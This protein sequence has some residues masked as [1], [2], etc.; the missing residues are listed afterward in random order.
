[1]HDAL[2][3]AAVSA[4]PMAAAASGALDDGFVGRAVE[5]R[6]IAELLAQDDCRLV[7]VVGPGGIGKTRFAQRAS[8]ELAARF[9]DGT[10]F[11]PLEDV[12]TAGE[13]GSRLAREMGIVISGGADPLKKV[14]AFLR[15]RRMLVVLDNFEHLAADAAL[16]DDVVRAC[17]Q[18]KFI[19]TSRVRLAIPGEW[20]L[21]LDGLPC[22]EPEDGDNVQ[23]F[24]AARLFVRQRSA[25]SPR[26]SR[27]PRRRPSWTS[28]ARPKACRWRWSSRPR[29]RACCRARRSP[30]S[31]DAA[32]SS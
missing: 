24:D 4:S 21:R 11:V 1:M 14:I 30:P 18:S 25:S 15:E 20:L 29:G 22:P 17:P 26:W 23:A 5:L 10:V 7:S 32:P 27:P 3:A 16:L 31:C 19:V 6:R 9:A 13:L 2:G 28:V 8:A 12:A